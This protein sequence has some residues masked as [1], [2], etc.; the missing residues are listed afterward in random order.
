MSFFSFPLPPSFCSRCRSPLT[1]S[2]AR[3]APVLPLPSVI[4]LTR[5][6][7]ALACLCHTRI[8]IVK[9]CRN[10]DSSYNLSTTTPDNAPKRG[11]SAAPM[12]RPVPSPSLAAGEPLSRASGSRVC[13]RASRTSCQ[14][15]SC[16]STNA[17]RATGTRPHPV[18]QTPANVRARPENF[19]TNCNLSFPS[20]HLA[21]SYHLRSISIAR[22][23][24]GS[25]PDGACSSDMPYLSSHSRAGVRKPHRATTT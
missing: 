24:S 3:P 6:Q 23:S 11:R 13:A 12:A 8:S 19:I 21:S 14:G 17:R 18:A 1:T 20:F 16:N 25:C 7:R 15:L 4:A 10:P 5:S 9:S 2:H 22:S